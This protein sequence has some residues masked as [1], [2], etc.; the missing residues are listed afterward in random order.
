MNRIPFSE[1]E[2]QIV[3]EY[4]KANEPHGSV[5]AL[6]GSPAWQI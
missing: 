5:K 6:C 3:G 4:L 2:L 1:A